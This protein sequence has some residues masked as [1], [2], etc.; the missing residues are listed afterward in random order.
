MRHAL[1]G[2][3]P[4]LRLDFFPGFAIPRSSLQTCSHAP[5]PPTSSGAAG[6]GHSVWRTYFLAGALFLPA[7]VR[8]GPFR[9]RAFVCVR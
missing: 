6:A 2:H 5:R 3:L 4:F 1:G 8:R 9:V 7:T